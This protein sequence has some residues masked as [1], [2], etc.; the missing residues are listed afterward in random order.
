MCNNYVT[1]IIN[2]FLPVTSCRLYL[3]ETRN[4]DIAKQLEPQTQS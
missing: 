1:I 2:S 4:K 3:A